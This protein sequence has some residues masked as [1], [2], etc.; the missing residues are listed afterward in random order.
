MPPARFPA[1]PCQTGPCKAGR[2]WEGEQGCGSGGGGAKGAKCRSGS[3]M[4][5]AG[6]SSGR[7]MTGAARRRSGGGQERGA[8]GERRRSSQVPQVGPGQLL[9][10]VPSQTRVATQAQQLPGGGGG[11]GRKLGMGMGTGGLLVDAPLS[12]VLGGGGGGGAGIFD[13]AEASPASRAGGRTC[14]PQQRGAADEGG[15]G[16]VHRMQQSFRLPAG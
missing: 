2:G 15:G 5:R 12:G 14:G 13:P 10:Q 1:P 8:V 11:G 16:Q 3:G 9:G 7:G 6:C 4:T